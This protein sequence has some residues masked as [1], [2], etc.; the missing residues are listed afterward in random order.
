MVWSVSWH[1][2]DALPA[3]IAQV[4]VALSDVVGQG[5]VRAM[6]ARMAVYQDWAQNYEDV[7]VC[8]QA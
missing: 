6:A 3:T 8:D 7:K 2:N 1:A 5:G 4:V